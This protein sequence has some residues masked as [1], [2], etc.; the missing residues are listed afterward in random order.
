LCPTVGW[1][2]NL[3]VDAE[4]VQ[5][6]GV[7]HYETVRVVNGGIIRVV[8]YDNGPDR[9]GF[10]NLQLVATSI[11]IDEDSGITADGA[12]YQPVFCGHGAGPHDDSGGRGG[13][14][15]MDSGGGGAHFGRGGR[16]TRDN[17]RGN[18][19]WGYEEDC[20]V[21][22]GATGCRAVS[23]CRDRDGLPSVAGVPYPHSIYEVEFG[24]AGGDRGC[25]DGDGWSNPCMTAGAGG[26]RIVLAAVAADGS[27]SLEIRGRVSAEG[28]R[29]CGNGNDSGGGGGGGTVVLAGDQVVTTSSAY[30]SAGGGLG[31]DTLGT[32]PDP[33][34]P[35]GQACPACAQRGGTCDDCGGG[36][37][38]GIIS[39]LSGSPAEL[40]SLS[41]FNVAGAGGGTCTNGN[42]IGEAGGGAGEL[43]LNLV[44]RGEYCD[45]YDNDFDGDIDEDLQDVTCGH[46]DCEVTVPGC[47]DSEPTQVVP[48]DCVP[49]AESTCQPTLSDTRSRFLVIVDSSGSMLLDPAGEFT[50]GDGSLGHEGVDTDGNGVAGD[51]S[52]LYQAKEALTQVI[53]A[54]IPDIDFGLARFSQ[55]T[56]EDVNCQLAHWF[57]CAGICCTYDDPTDNS[58]TNPTGPCFVDAGAAGSL[59]VLP[60]STGDECINYAGSCGSVRRGADILAGFQRPVGQLLM[61]LDHLETNFIND[62][63][64]GDHCDFS[65]G[66]DCELRATGPTPLADALHAAKAW[67]AATAAEDVIASC[68]D[69]SV[70]L[71][72]DGTETCFGD[73]V[74]AAGELLADLNVETYVIGF[75]VLASE[76]AALDGIAHAG[77]AS[78]ARG[79]FFA[80]DED[81]LATALA[82]IVAESVAFELCNGVDDDCDTLIDEDFPLLG[83]ECDDGQLG[84][85]RGTGQYECRGDGAGVECVIS[86]P[87]G[88]PSDEECNGVD[89]NCNG[90]IDE[91]LSCHA[92]CEPDGDEVCDGKDNNCNGAVDEDDPLL[93]LPCGEGEGLCSPGLWFC[94]LGDLMCLGAVEATSETCNGLDDD[95]DGAVDNDAE[96]PPDSWC[97]L[98]ACRTAC[99]SVEFP[100]PGGYECEEHTVDDE[101]LRVCMPGAC[102]LCTA[103]ELCVDGQCVDPCDAVS[104]NSGETC[105]LGVC[106]DCHTLGCSG[107]EV[108]YDGSCLPDPCAEVACDNGTEYCDNGRCVPLCHDRS[109]PAGQR[110]GLDGTCEPDLC[111]GQR[112]DEGEQCVGGSCVSDPCSAVY[113]A[114]GAVCVPPGE[115]VPDPCPLVSC[116]ADSRCEV[117]AQGE[118]VCKPLG[119]WTTHI[120]A[121]GA[122]G[123]M[124]HA[125][126]TP[127]T[128]AG[129]LPWGTVL[130]VLLFVTRRRGGGGGP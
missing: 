130:L 46:G 67:L 52:R 48:H 31:G 82:S 9:V 84:P 104:C 74:A 33:S 36:G 105:V 91:G 16:G 55:G 121:T 50:F 27:G 80:G 113:C 22:N 102:L 107:G 53:S 45:G 97:I 57:E 43:Q 81:S 71:L 126:P 87:G 34:D 58:G 14:A 66:G 115:C 10:G 38:G 29:G 24:A 93:G 76:R 125:A 124:C 94:V 98:G 63:T 49:L 118:G 128:A 64:E 73:P 109:C 116:S 54:Y 18:F 122:G 41:V 21:P 69:Y 4:V 78:G 110:C 37:G 123:C 47:D 1:T 83:E 86:S 59:E 19:P 106:R 35:F 23:G 70:I 62:R 7:H 72:T 11:F 26:G 6:S 51:D 60:E 15:V 117:V 44:Y 17:P 3:V 30:I 85:C 120:L 75:S 42:C 114:P 32:P 65:G 90:Q 20:G 99:Q 119:S 111:A 13:C 12:G 101:L 5:L 28:W 68:R 127:A 95:C 129:L 79:A 89:D 8:P 100:C 61:W 40:A 2:Q 103:Q 39:V 96:C 112:C 88:S 56:D 77:S 25:L 92:D 108:C